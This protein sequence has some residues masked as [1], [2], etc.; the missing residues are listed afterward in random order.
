MQNENAARKR[1]R[2]PAEP[3]QVV[4][5][6]PRIAYEYEGVPAGLRRGLGTPKAAL[7]S[8]CALRFNAKRGGRKVGYEMT[9][10]AL[11]R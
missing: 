3:Q 2:P 6:L 1:P 7:M 11:N 5:S 9:V 4:P 10:E 8:A